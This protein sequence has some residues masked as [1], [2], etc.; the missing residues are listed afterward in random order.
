V[1]YD[2]GKGIIA[3]NHNSVGWFAM[4]NEADAPKTLSVPE[5]GRKYFN[6]GK[7]S[8]YQA[9]QRGDLPVLRIGRRLRVSI[10]AIERMLAEA[11]TGR[12]P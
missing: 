1:T 4:N 5:A 3:L 6:L 9:A 10:I 11:G 8:S 12:G 7:N 2:D